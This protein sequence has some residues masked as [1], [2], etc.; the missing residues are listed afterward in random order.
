M[1]S[2]ITNIGEA[3]LTQHRDMG[4]DIV[5][6]SDYVDNHEQM[7]IDLKENEKEYRYI[8]EKASELIDKCETSEEKTQ[9]SK[10]LQ[11]I[12]Q[13]WNRLRLTV[14]QRIV[15]A[16]DYLDFI[17]LVAKFKNLSTDLNEL[18]KSINDHMSQTSPRADSIFEQHVLDKTRIIEQYYEELLIKGR[19][20]IASIK[21]VNST[22]Q[23]NFQLNQ[24]LNKIT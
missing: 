23:K 2:W 8:R 18:F 24:N 17:K 12:E 9:I 7:E 22:I 14:E 10:N 3:F 1:L 20:S 16:A 4:L 5:Y 6:V 13:K 21:K 11:L 15:V 19:Q